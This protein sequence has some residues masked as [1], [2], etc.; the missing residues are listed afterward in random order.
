MTRRSRRRALSMTLA[1]A[2]AVPQVDV[3]Q[4]DP[5]PVTVE[6]WQ[7]STSAR[8][9]SDGS[10]SDVV[11][12]SPNDVWAVGQQGIWDLWQNR[13]TIR[14]WNGTSWA[15][16]AIRDATGADNLRGVTATSPSDVWAV[17]DGHDGVPYL[18]NGDVTGFDRVRPQQLRVG[19]WLGGI[20]ARPGRVVA[21]GSRERNGLIVTG[22]RGAWTAQTTKEK[23]ALYA[24]SGPFAVGDTGSAPLI[25]K[26][27]DNAWK[28]VPVPSIPG[29]YLRD[30][31][32]DGVKRAIAVGGV[33]QAD[34]GVGPLVLM[35]NGKKWQRQKLEAGNA[36]LYGVAGDGKGRFWIAG[37]DPAQPAE[38]YMLRCEKGACATMR[39][40]PVKGRSSIRLQAVA[41]VPG[42][43]SV[44]AVGHSVDRNDRYTDV[45]ESFGPKSLV[46][47]DF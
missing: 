39:G 8:L 14:H 11:A 35:W 24:V 25:L 9:D 27:A 12:L 10:L 29:G 18:A 2:F 45:V 16:A 3:A 15:E 28:S 44:W 47:K 42:K 41:Y 37:Y 32:A 19:D 31:Q 13:G 43:G 36:R 17:G 5:R 46:P 23:G 22:E 7:H 30:V 6:A 33:H 21:V 34:G 38:A 40:E 20:D 4:A 26:Y 1:L